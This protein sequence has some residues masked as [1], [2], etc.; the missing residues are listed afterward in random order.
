[1]GQTHCH[2]VGVLDRNVRARE[3]V[4][5]VLEQPL[6]DDSVHGLSVRDRIHVFSVD[7]PLGTSEGEDLVRELVLAAGS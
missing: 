3:H 4:R 2:D 1:M 6:G 5:D 7:T